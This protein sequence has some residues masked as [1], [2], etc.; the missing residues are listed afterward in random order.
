MGSN[1]RLG[2]TA[3]ERR[4]GEGRALRA[5]SDLL[6][7]TVIGPD[8]AHAP[9]RQILLDIGDGHA[10]RLLHDP[11][12]SRLA[13]W[14]RAWAA[15]SMAYLGDKR[16]VLALVSAL[17]DEHWRVRMNS[18][19][20]L[21]RLRVDGVT[22]SLRRTLLDEHPRV[23]HAAVVALGRVGDE[24]AMR[25]LTALL[26]TSDATTARHIERAIGEIDRRA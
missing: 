13:H 26:E 18:I 23:R 6:S 7:G 22:D 21:G 20:S 2:T 16:A 15:R 17:S 10:S 25:D 8:L 14:P 9:W 3:L 4:L 1:P 12:G 5:L 19:M 11:T 24:S